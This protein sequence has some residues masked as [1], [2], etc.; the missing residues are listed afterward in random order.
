MFS[1]R[2]GDVFQTSSGGCPGVFWSTAMWSDENISIFTVGLQDDLR[3]CCCCAPIV[4]EY[5]WIYVQNWGHIQVFLVMSE[6]TKRWVKSLQV[7]L[8]HLLNGNKKMCNYTSGFGNWVFFSFHFKSVSYLLVAVSFLW[9]AA[10]LPNACS[11]RAD[12]QLGQKAVLE[13]SDNC[14]SC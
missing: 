3:Y 8:E 9:D 11:F 12:L 10:V 14:W 7:R 1:H 6:W 5:K 13:L 2:W 4:F